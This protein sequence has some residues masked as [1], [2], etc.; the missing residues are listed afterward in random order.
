MGSGQYPIVSIA[1][2]KAGSDRFQFSQANATRHTKLPAQSNQQSALLHCSLIISFKILNLRFK[3]NAEAGLWSHSY[4]SHA[5]KNIHQSRLHYIYLRN[6]R[7]ILN[8]PLT[9][10]PTG[11]RKVIW[12]I[13]YNISR[14]NYPLRF[15]E[16]YQNNP[17][18]S[19]VW[20]IF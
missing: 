13:S 12:R 10:W 18:F 15:H 2:M 19:S 1:V 11:H 5:K 20:E 8:Y 9:R 4:I 17:T 6:P 7:N 14:S 3:S 16:K